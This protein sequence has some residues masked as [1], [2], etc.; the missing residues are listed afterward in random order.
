M[1]A[2]FCH[3]QF[4]N[5]YRSSSES[6]ASACREIQRNVGANVDLGTGRS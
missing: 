2:D 3:Q 1:P 6:L 4:G 5:S